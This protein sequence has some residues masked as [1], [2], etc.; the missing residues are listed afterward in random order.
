MKPRFQT[1]HVRPAES[2]AF[3]SRRVGLNHT[4]HMKSLIILIISSGTIHLDSV[5]IHRI[6]EREQVQK[7]LT[8]PATFKTNAIT[9][10]YRPKI[11]KP[12]PQ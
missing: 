9:V 7:I 8:L 5:A 12:L 10:M 1:G 2:P 6:H 11:R 3:R 4:P